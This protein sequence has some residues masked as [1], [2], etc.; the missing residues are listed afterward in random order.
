V[1]QRQ[2]RAI[3]G[4]ITSPV[5]GQAEH[6]DWPQRHRVE[7]VMPMG[8]ISMGARREMLA[9]VVERCRKT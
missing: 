1:S 3:E 7:S 8:K 6:L 4:R 5:S 9:A 2:P